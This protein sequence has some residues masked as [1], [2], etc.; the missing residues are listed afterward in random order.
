M[1]ARSRRGSACKGRLCCLT[2]PA[3]PTELQ[4]DGMCTEQLTSPPLVRT[5]V[6]GTSTR[7]AWWFNC[8]FYSRARVRTFPHHD[9][10]YQCCKED[11]KD[12]R[13]FFKTTNRQKRSSI[14]AGCVTSALD[15]FELSIRHRAQSC[16]PCILK[17]VKLAL[18]NLY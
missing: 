14:L 10:L 12:C 17:P 1:R 5:A 9:E 7:R 16:W 6:A 3:P 4:L 13:R 18:A 2:E 15:L 8:C 11:K